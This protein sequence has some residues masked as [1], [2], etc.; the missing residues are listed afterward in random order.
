MHSLWYKFLS[1]SYCTW[2]INF[3]KFA[4]SIST[5]Q[6]Y[7][8][9][10]QPE[11]VGVWDF[12]KQTLGAIH[13][14]RGQ[15]RAEGVWKNFTLVHEREGGSRAKIPLILWKYTSIGLCV[16]VGGGANKCLKIVHVV[17]GWLLRI[18]WEGENF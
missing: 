17:Y 8:L 3:I 2:I 4:S 1:C 14:P 12:E 5:L 11:W 7:L 6:Q 13:I 16:C 9:F 18:F 10:S 15:F